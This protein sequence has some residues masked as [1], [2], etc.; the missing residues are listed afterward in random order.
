M[1][2]ISLREC[3]QVLINQRKL[4]AS[5]TIIVVL[6]SA[7]LNFFIMSPVYEGKVIL[8]ASGI[9]SRQAVS[10]QAEGVEAF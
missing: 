6:S 1:E 8:M 2:E 4:I 7:V 10:S 9:N 3:I 5:I